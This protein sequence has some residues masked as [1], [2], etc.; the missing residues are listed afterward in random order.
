MVGYMALKLDMSKAYDRI[1]WSFLECMMNKIG[2]CTD[3]VNLI[4]KCVNTVSYI[5]RINGALTDT[6]WPGRGLRQGD[7]ISP[8]LFL[9]CVE[10][11]STM[12]TQAKA[13]GQLQ[14]IK[15]APEAST[16]SHLLFPDDSLLLLEANE[17]AA[18]TVNHILQ[19]YEA[20]SGQVINRDKSSIMFSTNTK[21]GVRNAV[22]QVLGLMSESNGGKYLG[23]PTYIG[24]NRV[25]CFEFI[26]EKIWKRIQGWK[27]KC[28]SKTGKEILIKS[29]AQAIPIYAMA[30]FDLMKG[31]CD[32][33]SQLICKYWWSQDNNEKMM[34]WVGWE[35]MKLGKEEGA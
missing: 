10:G 14:G 30:C 21:R 1:E 32:S 34:H 9:L 16:V 7:P 31:L 13:D 27:E 28:L 18:H 26:K 22:M 17:N 35:K 25:Q 5:F 8:Y 19:V 29:V 2:F 4:M 33:I 11:L 15:L 20:C 3:F 24:H 23:L 12:L 6:F